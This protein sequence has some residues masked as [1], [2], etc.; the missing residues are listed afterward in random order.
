MPVVA[1]IQAR[2]GSIRLPGKVLADL[3]GMPVLGWVVR[4]AR[5]I[6]GVDAAVVATSTAAAD[7]AIADWAA[8]NGVTAYRGPEEDV[9]ARYAAAAKAERARIV[10]RIT[11]DCPLL[12]PVEAG[13]VIAPVLAGNADFASNNDPPTYPDGLD[14]EAFTREAL[15][16]AA[17]LARRPS[18]R[19]HVTPYM[20][21]PANRFRIA[22]IHGP[23]PEL[24][25]HRWT[26]DRPED[27]VLLR[28]LAATL[29]ADRPP[30]MAE[31]LGVLDNLPEL[32]RLNLGIDRNEGYA[33]S[34]ARDRAHG[35]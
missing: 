25:E 22:H 24:A 9:L 23:G 14:C 15:E 27:L 29:A 6:P 30:R 33:K 18:E 11:A 8:E 4:A 31:V 2:M 34:L 19:E 26:L 5:A 20:R 17:A 28:A 32:R 13:K 35:F 1:I 12:D 3:A 16:Q 10:V 21:D 7:Q